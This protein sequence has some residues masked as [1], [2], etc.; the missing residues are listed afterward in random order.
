MLLLLGSELAALVLFIDVVSLYVF[1][2]LLEVQLLIARADNT[3]LIQSPAYCID[4]YS[5]GLNK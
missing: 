1:L 2:L 3:A 4:R 5:S